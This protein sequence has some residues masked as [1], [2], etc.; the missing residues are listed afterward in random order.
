LLQYKS[1]SEDQ[2]VKSIRNQMLWYVSF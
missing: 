1:T 2:M